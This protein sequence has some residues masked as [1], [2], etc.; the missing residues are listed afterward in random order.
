MATEFRIQEILDRL[1][2]RI[3]DVLPI[4]AAGVTL[5]S[6]GSG[7]L[8]VAAS[9]AAAL[10]FERLQSELDEGPCLLAYSS[11]QAVVVAD[12]RNERRFSAFTTRALEEGLAA[13]FTF[14]L[15]S[16]AERIGALDLY[17]DEPGPLDPSTMATAQTLADVVTAYLRNAQTRTE[18]S[19]SSERA[20]F[21][22][23]HDPLTGLANRVLLIELVD[24]AARRAKRS[25]RTT[26]VM[27]A[28]LDR[29]KSVND[30]YGHRIGDELLVGVADRLS[31]ILR[32]GD[33][34]ARL[35]GDE[36]VMVCEEL[37]NTEQADAVAR[38]VTSS[39][40][41]PMTLSCGPVKVAVSVGVAFVHQGTD[42]AEDVLHEAD[43]A[44]YQA[45]AKGGDRHQAIDSRLQ[46][47][48][49]QRA[50]LMNDLRYAQARGEL[51]LD[52]QPM[53][54]MADGRIDGL[55]ALLR[56]NHPVYG[57]VMPT[58][59]IPLAEQS[60]LIVDMGLWV[61]RQACL[62]RQRVGRTQ[63]G[64]IPDLSV[65]VSARQLMAPDFAASVEE[66]LRD[67]AAAADPGAVTLEVTESLLISDRARARVVLMELKELGVKLAL[68]DFG[69]GYS[70]FNY[71]DEFPVDVVK[72]DRT[73]IAG[74]DQRASARAI[75]L[76]IVTLAHSLTMTV[77]AEGV[78]TA[79]QYDQVARLGCDT[80]QGFFICPSMPVER[81]DLF[82]ERDSLASLR[83]SVPSPA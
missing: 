75:V 53:V 33:T 46:K 49:D 7:P 31:R 16:G 35:A 40:D 79:H 70:S 62:D 17:R 27:F 20:R 6:P 80:C 26:A 30:T 29:F 66:V 72:I 74:I 34:L 78:E 60:G 59:L 69:T 41:A 68:D 23:L 18:L 52:Y 77:V 19:E 36:F 83:L 15:R 54:R 51:I 8:Y 32:P 5:I 48:E 24:L 50:D 11:G 39:F 21:A 65:N 25:G 76:S 56:W 2:E 1:V 37:D 55:E 47:L 38:R 12:L 64:A 3:V 22:S 10:R 71:L 63:G 58:A 73:F 43:T 82:M 42:A 14:P 81:L 67:P 61:L 57:R 13:V 45:K 28:D 44:M 9:D 4:T